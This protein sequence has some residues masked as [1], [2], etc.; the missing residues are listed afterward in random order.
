MKRGG[1]EKLVAQG[2]QTCGSNTGNHIWP[3]SSET[4][5]N[6]MCTCG[7]FSTVI[8]MYGFCY[9]YAKYL[10]AMRE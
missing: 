9:S 6:A 4:T 1:G 3:T 10:I 5:V 8:H 2:L 7:S